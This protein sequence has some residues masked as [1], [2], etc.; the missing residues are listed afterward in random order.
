MGKGGNLGMEEL[1]YRSIPL[2]A[3]S[4]GD[5]WAGSWIYLAEVST[6]IFSQ[7]NILVHSFPVHLKLSG[8]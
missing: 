7:I 2:Q 8:H 4:G 3:G 1:F 6:S 5:H